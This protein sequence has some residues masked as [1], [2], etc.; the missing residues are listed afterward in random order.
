[1]RLREMK[2]RARADLKEAQRL[3]A[4]LDGA[5]EENLSANGVKAFEITFSDGTK[6]VTRDCRCFGSTRAGIHDNYGCPVAQ[7]QMKGRVREK[8]QPFPMD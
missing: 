1:M 5:K 4:Q 8:I 3:M 2:K 6:Q 7:K